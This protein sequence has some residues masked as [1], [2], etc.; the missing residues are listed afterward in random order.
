MRRGQMASEEDI[1]VGRRLAEARHAAGLTQAEVGRQLGI[2]QSRIA[3]LEIG[4]RRLLFSE[5][6]EFATLYKVKLAAFV[7]EVPEKGEG[8][9]ESRP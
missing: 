5:A 1:A 3:K 2:A 7:A 6:L 9:A 4:T 8:P